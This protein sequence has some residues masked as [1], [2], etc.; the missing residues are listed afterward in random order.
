MQLAYRIGDVLNPAGL[1]VTHV[2]DGVNTVLSSDQYTLSQLDSAEA[3]QKTITVSYAVNSDVTLTAAFTVSV[4]SEIADD[5]RLELPESLVF[6]A[7]TDVTRHI[8]VYAVYNGGT[9]MELSAGTA[10]GYLLSGV[11]TLVSGEQTATVTYSGI[12]KT[13]KITVNGPSYINATASSTVIP[14]EVANMD[15]EEKL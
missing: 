4:V 13:F 12:E 1:E 6:D 11:D 15:P 10:D 7:A 9:E 14:W 2:K 3:G 8:K 5:L